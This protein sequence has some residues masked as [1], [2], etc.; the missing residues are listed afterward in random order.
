MLQP[1][2]KVTLLSDGFLI[3]AARARLVGRVL[4][5]TGVSLTTAPGFG[6]NI[7]VDDPLSL[8]IAAPG[9]SR[10]M[11]FLVVL[12]PLAPGEKEPTIAGTGRSVRIGTREILFDD[13]GHAPPRLIH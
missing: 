2:G 5:P 12:V 8:R 6:G 7:N 3:E 10:R 9:K 4:L 11:E 1:G 13:S